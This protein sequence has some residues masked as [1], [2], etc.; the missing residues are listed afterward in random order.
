[1]R[2]GF[3]D[4]LFEIL[5]FSGFPYCA[6]PVAHELRE[7]VEEGA[8]GIT[9]LERHLGVHDRVDEGEDVLLALGGADGINFMEGVLLQI[10]GVDEL[11]LEVA[12]EVF[13]CRAFFANN[14]HHLGN[15]VPS[16]QHCANF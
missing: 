4:V 11:R 14:L 3:V 8:S 10:N 12:D 5:E 2:D 9:I 13:N 1:M 15:I 7:F 16:F 6:V